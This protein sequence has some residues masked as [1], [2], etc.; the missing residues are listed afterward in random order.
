M[1]KIAQKQLFGAQV[2]FGLAIFE[3]L[4]FVMARVP[5]QA[6]KASASFGRA[7]TK[8]KIPKIAQP[9]ITLVQNNCFCP[10]F[11]MYFF[12]LY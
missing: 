2:I 8:T 4:V 11:G 1:P 12:I 6:G 5:R 7:I 3:I 9:K 10:I